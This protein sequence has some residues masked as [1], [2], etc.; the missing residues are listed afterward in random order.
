MEALVKIIADYPVAE[1]T[2]I[3]AKRS[4]VKTRR[5]SRRSFLSWVGVAWAAFTAAAATISVATAPDKYPKVLFEPNK[6]I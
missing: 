6:T 2:T 4:E 1:R 3:N 5:L